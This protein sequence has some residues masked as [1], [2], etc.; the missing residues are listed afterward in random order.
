MASL[1]SFSHGDDPLK[2]SIWADLPRDIIYNIIDQSDLLTLISWSNTGLEFSPYA[3]AKLWKGHRINH[4]SDQTIAESVVSLLS[5]PGA[6]QKMRALSVGQLVHREAEGFAQLVAGLNLVTLELFCG[7]TQFDATTGG[8][9]TSPLVPFLQALEINTRTANCQRTRRLPWSLIALWLR[10]VRRANIPHLHQLIAK[11]IVP[12]KALVSFQIT[13]CLSEAAHKKLEQLEL[14]H[15][16]ESTAH[17]TIGVGSWSALSCD[18]P[19]KMFCHYFGRSGG[20]DYRVQVRSRHQ[21]DDWLEFTNLAKIMDDVIAN[22]PRG[23]MTWRKMDFIRRSNIPDD[24]IVIYPCQE[25]C[26]E[27][28]PQHEPVSVR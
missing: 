1:E 10:D 25:A 20:G 21:G 4:S 11:A 22:R 12:F 17:E 26:H 27:G 3:R 6:L 9:N 8:N 5:S 28:H 7:G 14:P 19:K 13:F 16:H 18:M 24:A 2:P 15:I 23:T